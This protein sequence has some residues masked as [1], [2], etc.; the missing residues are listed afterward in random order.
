MKINLKKS[1]II[2]LTI[3]IVAFGIMVPWL[4]FYNEILFTTSLQKLYICYELWPNFLIQ[5]IYY[6]GVIF[7][8]CYSMPLVMIVV[9]YLLIGLKVWRRGNLGEHTSSA[10]VIQ[11]S[12]VK[13]IKMLVVVCLLFAFSW[14]PMYG[15]KFWKMV[16][17]NLEEEKGKI[18]SEI[19]FPVSQWL[20]SSNCCV[21]PLIYCFFSKKFRKGFRDLV[22]CCDWKVKYVS[23]S[24]ETRV[25]TLRCNSRHSINQHRL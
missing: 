21:N 7:I 11:R 4:I 14:M 19:L 8:C 17:P 1:R 3:W 20:G 16:Q 13:V 12:K 18:F 25:T 5:Q 22:M 23:G 6:M 10:D 2:L 15:L 24:P 9:C